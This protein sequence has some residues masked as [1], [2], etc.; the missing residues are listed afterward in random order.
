MVLKLFL[1]L[2]SRLFFSFFHIIILIILY[3]IELIVVVDII[4]IELIFE[5]KDNLL[6]EIF[7]YNFKTL[8][9]LLYGFFLSIINIC[10]YIFIY[11]TVVSPNQYATVHQNRLVPKHSI[12]MNK[13]K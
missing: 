12:P 5:I 6:V 7:T 2:I 3:I 1:K 11:K 4:I 13:L 9:N 10:I 8:N